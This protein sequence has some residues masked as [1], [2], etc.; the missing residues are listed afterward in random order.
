MPKETPG[1]SQELL[2]MA[3]MSLFYMIL[4]CLVELGFI[5]RVVNMIARE[6]KVAFANTVLDEDVKEEKERVTN[7]MQQGM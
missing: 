1:I 5:K 2:F 6:N 7:L 3:I 4:L